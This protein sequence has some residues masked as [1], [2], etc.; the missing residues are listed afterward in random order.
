MSEGQWAMLP[1]SKLKP[2]HYSSSLISQF[3]HS[4]EEEEVAKSNRPL[5]WSNHR[6]S[7]ER[8]LAQYVET[9]SFKLQAPNQGGLQAPPTASP[10][11]LMSFQVTMVKCMRLGY[12]SET[13]SCNVQGIVSHPDQLIAFFQAEDGVGLPEQI[14]DQSSFETAAKFYFIFTRFDILWSLNYFAL[15]VLNFL[16][17]CYRPRILRRESALNLFNRSS[18]WLSGKEVDSRGRQVLHPVVRVKPL[19]CD[20]H[21]AFSCNNREYYFLG[22]LPYL[23]GA[24]SL[25]YEGVTLIILMIHTFF[26]ISYEGFSIYWKSALNIL[27]KHNNVQ[28]TKKICQD[29]L[30]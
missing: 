22:Q 8:W 14:L 3:L 20:E 25:V 26:P 7:D 11:L 6:S 23:T 16:E 12:M 30:Q 13:C 9:L 21:S 5:E 18:G 10:S 2:L 27:K 17:S 29:C 19:W 1:E 15:I 28:N 24:E 4:T